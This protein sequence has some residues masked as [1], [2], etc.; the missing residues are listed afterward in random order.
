MGREV[1]WLSVTNNEKDNASMNTTPNEATLA[2]PVMPLGITE[3]RIAH[4]VAYN[5]RHLAAIVIGYE[6]NHADLAVFTNMKNV[7]GTQSFGIQFH[8]AVVY[9]ET[10]TPGTW[11]YPEWVGPPKE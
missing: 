1:A 11:H 8:E 7:A 9:S 3:G 5:K 10:P 2:E 4:Y 6:G